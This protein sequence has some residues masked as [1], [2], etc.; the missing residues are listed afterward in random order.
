MKVKDTKKNRGIL[1]IRMILKRICICNLGTGCLKLQKDT[2]IL[3]NVLNLWY[4]FKE[5]CPAKQGIFSLFYFIGKERILW[6]IEEVTTIKGKL[7]QNGNTMW[8]ENPN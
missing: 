7:R 8:D 2:Y 1:F 6:I 3:S 5:L 4:R